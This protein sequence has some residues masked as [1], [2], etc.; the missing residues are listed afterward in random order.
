MSHSLTGKVNFLFFITFYTIKTKTVRFIKK[1]SKSKIVDF[2]E[3]N[4]FTF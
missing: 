4:N 3:M 1:W 2:F